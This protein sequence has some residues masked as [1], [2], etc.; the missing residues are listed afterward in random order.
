MV[1]AVIVRGAAKYDV[2]ILRVLF[3]SSKFRRRYDPHETHHEGLDRG[4]TK[5]GD[6][7]AALRTGGIDLYGSLA[8]EGVDLKKNR[9]PDRHDY[10]R[11]R[12]KL[13]ALRRLAR[14]QTFPSRS[15]IP[16]TGRTPYCSGSQPS[17]GVN[18]RPR[19]RLWHT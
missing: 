13:F 16:H 6:L 9:S 7:V 15:D 8:N 19:T 11:G 3:N 4:L 5:T 12:A 17:G 10:L 14:F 2:E 18:L 1:G